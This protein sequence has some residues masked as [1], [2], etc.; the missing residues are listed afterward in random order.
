MITRG[1]LASSN[2]PP[3]ADDATAETLELSE[4]PAAVVCAICGDALCPGCLDLDE[5]TR[6]SGVVAVV[7]WERE[8][9]GVLRRLWA[10][11]RLATLCCES[12]FG[13]LP[14][15]E[16]T[17]A[18]RFALLSEL[19]TVAGLIVTTAPLLLAVLPM[20]IVAVIATPEWSVPLAR[21]LAYTVPGLA[22]TMVAIHAAHGIGLDLG[23]RRQGSRR[24]R[25]M[26]LRFGLY[27]CGWDLVTL[28]LG[29]AIVTVSDGFGAGRDAAKLA[30]NAPGRAARAYLRQY[31]GVV[32]PD[33]LRR[34]Q[35]YG[36]L[37]AVFVLLWFVVALSVAFLA[38]TL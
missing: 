4:V 10:T 2:P 17:K 35:R 20:P 9:Q 29:I 30:L 7:P 32:D 15:G 26:G 1:A 3:Q 18:F 33:R 19:L 25:G 22:L 31:H 14:T 13:A 11:A 16:T 36:V 27:A 38:R 28:P 21:G 37:S 34:A 6:P 8:G 24:S 12:F 5:S 23:A